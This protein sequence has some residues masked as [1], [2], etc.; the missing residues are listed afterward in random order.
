MRSIPALLRSSLWLLPTLGLAACSGSSGKTATVDSSGGSGGTA[1]ASTGGSGGVG[2]TVGT[3]GASSGGA[4]GT[5]GGGGVAGA[6]GA[7]GSTAYSTERWGA[8]LWGTP[9][10]L[11]RVGRELWVGTRGNA[12]PVADAT[13]D[14]RGGLL[15]VNL[16]TG[17]VKVFESELPSVPDSLD[18][19][20]RGPP[21]T[22]GVIADGERRLVASESGILVIDGEQPVQLIPVGPGATSARVV[23]LT[24]DRSAGRNSLWAA[25]D[26]GLVEL[27]ADTLETRRTLA[28]AE[29]GASSVGDLALD[30]STGAVY[31]AVYGADD[32]WVARVG[33]SVSTWTPGSDNLQDGTVADIVFAEGKAYVALAAWASSDGGIVSWNGTSAESVV[34]EGE[35]SWAAEGFHRGFG[36]WE[37]DYIEA[38]KT[39]VVGGRL[40]PGVSGGGVAYIDLEARAPARGFG[41]SS[42][43]RGLPG[44]HVGALAHDPV[45]GR[46]F[47]SLAMPCSESKL[48]IQGL[49]GLAFDHGKLVLE[50]PLLSGVRDVAMHDGDV[51]MALRDEKPGY[52]CDGL[53]VS[54]GVVK[55]LNNKTAEHIPGTFVRDDG[56]PIDFNAAWIAPSLLATGG[57]HLA[58]TG[59]REG[60]W[61]GFPISINYNQAIDFRLSLFIND[62]RWDQQGHLWMSGRA[63]TDNTA[64]VNDRSPRGTARIEVGQNGVVGHLQFA[65]SSEDTTTIG[66]LPSN[67]VSAVLPLPDGD[68]LVLCATERDNDERDRAL[69]EPYDPGT[70]IE[71]GGIARISGKTVS[72]VAESDEAPDPIAGVVMASGAAHVADATRGLLTLEN[73]TLTQADWPGE[74]P[75]GSRP[76]AVQLGSSSEL[77]VGFD[78]GLLLMTDTESYFFAGNGFTWRGM[79]LPQGGALVGTDEG[80]LLLGAPELP[81]GVGAEPVVSELPN[82]ED[83][84]APAD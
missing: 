62:L 28:G 25:T 79:A 13:S 19:D 48:G 74:V 64:E 8:R 9:L 35:L 73:D 67:A 51:L 75:A 20:L 63:S 65:R 72:I 83:L 23:D 10:A 68:A 18:P 27:D 32:S 30:P 29:L 15:R 55:L 58:Y 46:T 14:R 52:S 53:P 34:V 50:R 44:N 56:S 59:N 17:D 43:S 69:G 38:T 11:S 70:G 49:F 24:L 21:A 5:A 42:S 54:R 82:L 71:L 31:A 37:L 41:V 36:A 78:T 6:G 61:L 57:P 22:R 80:L 3:G 40:A 66:G 84:Q 47:V 16:D 4:A 26:A 76:V 39:L 12:D 60:L 1:G 77:L 81:Q 2:A 33:S 45:T 7:G